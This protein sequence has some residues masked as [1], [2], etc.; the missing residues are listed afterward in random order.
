MHSEKSSQVLIVVMLCLV[1]DYVRTCVSLGGSVDGS[2]LC[3]LMRLD[4]PV[5]LDMRHFSLYKPGHTFSTLIMSYLQGSYCSIR[6]TVKCAVL[7]G[8]FSVID[9]K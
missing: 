5:G 2:L 9:D 7:L 3:S 6:I 8:Q 4:F 1:Y